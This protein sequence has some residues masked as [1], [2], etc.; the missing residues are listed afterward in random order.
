MI[1]FK[2]AHS[3]FLLSVLS[4]CFAT[5][6]MGQTQTQPEKKKTSKADKKAAKREMVN[7]MVKA[8][9]EGAIVYAKQWVWG[10]RLYS[11]G[12]STYYEKGKKT[13]ATKGTLYNIEIG[14]RKH[15]KEQKITKDGGN[16]IF[17]GNPLVYGKRNN[18]YFTRLGI[19]QQYLI[20]GKGNKNGVAVFA[21]Y[22][23]GL[24]IGLLKPYYVDIVDP[25]S[26]KPATIKYKDDG[27]R[28]DSLFLD[29]YA[30]QGGSGFTKG[31]NEMKVVP[32]LNAH[33]GLRF[34]YGRYNEIVSAIQVG[35]R[36]EYYFSDM[37]IMVDVPSHNFFTNVFVSFEFGR[38][39]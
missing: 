1:V 5:I 7:Q 33:L 26:G 2:S 16:G 8:E 11:D 29:P 20:G 17:F 21:V 28:N 38:R 4:L 14:E 19:G 36:S 32:G 18:F 31:F 25:V 6:V 10:F 3:K 35:V 27:S 15:P 23:G 22:G 9:E 12:W 24:S 39:K 30:L 37:P 13:S 34:D